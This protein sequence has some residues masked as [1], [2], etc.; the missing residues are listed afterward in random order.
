MDPFMQLTNGGLLFEWKKN[1]ADERNSHCSSFL[2][3]DK[4]LKKDTLL[5]CCKVIFFTIVIIFN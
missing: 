2:I 4:K 5:S 1:S 3:E